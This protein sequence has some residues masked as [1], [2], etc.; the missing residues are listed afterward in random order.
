ML[1]NGMGGLDWAGLP[2]VC[3]MLGVDDMDA[4]VH[5]LMVIKLHQPEQAGGAPQKG[6]DGSGDTLG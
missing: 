3:R 6:N 2:L 1:S 4:L 5:D